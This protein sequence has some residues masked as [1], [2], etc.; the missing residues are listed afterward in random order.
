MTLEVAHGSTRC[1]TDYR[2]HHPSDPAPQDF[3]Q[4]GCSDTAL[5]SPPVNVQRIAAAATVQQLAPALI[6][7]VIF[8]PTG[9]Q[10]RLARSSI[11]RPPE[12]PRS[13]RTTVLLI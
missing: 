1:M 11:H 3:D 5:S 10:H 4:H 2:R 12:S 13:L 7:Y 9:S 8:R 6:S